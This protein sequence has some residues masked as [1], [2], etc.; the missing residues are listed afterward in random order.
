M[1]NLLLVVK[2]SR[3]PSSAV[4]EAASDSEPTTRV[5]C[6]V[7][8]TPSYFLHCYLFR[9]F[10]CHPSTFSLGSALSSPPF[11]LLLGL[12]LSLLPFG[13]LPWFR[14]FFATLR[15]S[16]LVRFFLCCSSAFSLGSVLSSPPFGLLP[17]FGSF[18]ATL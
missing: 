10:L 14:S 16:S 5:R 1:K 6:N 15:P 4:R 11:D 3:T 18:F 2:K 7:C 9:F 13:L 8:S 17:W 12:V